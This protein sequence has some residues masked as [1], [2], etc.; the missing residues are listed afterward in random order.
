M[1][2]MWDGWILIVKKQLDRINRIIRIKRIYLKAESSREKDY[3][4]EKV[5]NPFYRSS[6]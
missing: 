1:S 4:L 3:A 6:S 2:T 5:D